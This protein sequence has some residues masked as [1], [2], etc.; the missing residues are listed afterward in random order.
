[1]MVTVFT[2]SILDPPLVNLD[3]YLLSYEYD[4][5]VATTLLLPVD[6][7][8]FYLQFPGLK[9]GCSYATGWPGL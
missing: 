1:M 4:L 6:L 9:P 7:L 3:H 8:G 5:T 2:A